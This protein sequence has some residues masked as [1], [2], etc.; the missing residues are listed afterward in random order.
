M[1]SRTDSEMADRI[2]LKM[3]QPTQL[4]CTYVRV[5]WDICNL[6]V[7]QLDVCS[8]L[9]DEDTSTKEG[10]YRADYWEDERRPKA[11]GHNIFILAKQVIL[12][13]HTCVCVCVLVRVYTCLL[14]VSLVVPA[15]QRFAGIT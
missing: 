2:L 13:C 15:Q 8:R 7:L 10:R 1:E 3:N 6:L 14:C 5:Y 11:V 4:V 9:Y 12:L